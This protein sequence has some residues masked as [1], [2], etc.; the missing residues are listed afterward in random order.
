MVNGNQRGYRF[1]YDS[2]QRLKNAIYAQGT[3]GSGSWTDISG[4]EEKNIS[5]D[6][7]GNI[8]S[9][10]RNALLNNTGLLIAVFN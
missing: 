7:N 9:L 1:D 2:A 6:Q 4:Y 10:Q 3:L 5:Y 8:L